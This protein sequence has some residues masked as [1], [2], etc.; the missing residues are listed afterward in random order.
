MAY[1][2]LKVFFTVLIA[3]AVAVTVLEG[4]EIRLESGKSLFFPSIDSENLSYVESQLGC[5]TNCASA[6]LTFSRGQ[7][8]LQCTNHCGCAALISSSASSLQKSTKLDYTI[9]IFY[10]DSEQNGTIVYVQDDATNATTQIDIQESKSDN[11]Y[12]VNVAVNDSSKNESG[13]EDEA[14]F[15]YSTEGGYT[16]VSAEHSMSSGEEGSVYAVHYEETKKNAD[17]TTDTVTSD[18]VD[19]YTNDGKGHTDS[20]Y[21]YQSEY[22]HSDGETET[23]SKHWGADIGDDG[24]E[25]TEQGTNTESNSTSYNGTWHNATSNS[26][27]EYGTANGTITNG[28]STS[29]VSWW[30][31]SQQVT[32]ESGGNGWVSMLVIFA[33]MAVIGMV[34]YRKFTEETVKRYSFAERESN[35]NYIRI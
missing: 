2:M 15:S 21:V 24:F 1:K 8:T 4:R 26:T 28:E 33:V 34:A 10:P 16:V 22:T 14:S 5:S 17:G 27:V 13:N 18:S 29:S 19:V 31:N 12:S 9:D 23:H 3:S 32:G 25:I 6:C 30:V 11:S 35:Q 7:A 20:D